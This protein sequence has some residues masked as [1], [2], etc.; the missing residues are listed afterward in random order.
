MVKRRNGIVIEITDGVNYE[1]RGNLYYSLA[2]ISTIHLAEAMANDLKEHNITAVAVTPGF[3]RS[4]AMLDLFGVS[5]DNWQEGVKKDPHFIES[6]TPFY[7]GKAVAE[8]ACDLKSIEKTGKVLSSW[9]LAKE[10]GFK[11]IDGR[12]PDW[13]AYY[14]MNIG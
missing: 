5:E 6:E 3:L 11:D 13:G 10:Y 9:E 1:Y 4:E 14:R 12:Q 8:L 2:K 7:I